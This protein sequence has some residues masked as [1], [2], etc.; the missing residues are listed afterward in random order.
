MSDVITK[1]LRWRQGSKAAAS[2]T[3]EVLRIGEAFYE[4]DTKDFKIGDGSTKYR[5]LLGIKSEAKIAEQLAKGVY[6]GT[7][8]E[9]KFADE[10]AGYSSVADWLHARCAANDFT[11]IYP[12]DYFYDTT[13]AQTVDGTAVAAG[14]K[15]KCVIAGIDMYYNND[16]SLSE[17]AENFSIS[18]Q[19]VRSV[20]KK[21]ETILTEMEEKLNLA[22]RFGTVQEKSDMIAARLTELNSKIN[23]SFVSNEIDLII[24]QI[25]ELADYTD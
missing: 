6:R 20:L 21:G 1:R 11:G 13:V 24:K 19:G 15:R 23:D 5:K 2:S 18:R 16:L 9:E 8:L 22:S 17:I 3:N 4:T 10:I 7:N 14:Q 25:K 12:F